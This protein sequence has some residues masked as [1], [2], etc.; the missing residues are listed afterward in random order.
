VRLILASGSPRRRELIAHLGV[1][2]E[3][4]VSGVDEAV[5][6]G[7][8]PDQLVTRLARSKAMEVSG[9]HADAIVLA[10]DTI[11]VLRGDI[12]NKPLDADDA[13]DML[14]RLRGRQHRVITAVAVTRPGGRTRVRRVV[15][16][17]TM[18]PYSDSEVEAWIAGGSPFDKAG[19]YAVQDPL[20]A[21]VARHEGC[22][23][24]IVGLPL[25][26]T[27]CMLGAAGVQASTDDL[28]ERCL[29]C[30]L[31]DSSDTQP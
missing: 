4:A 31:R 9:Q 25:W 5:S 8:R 13:R 14:A 12:L 18:R 6:A 16:R 30:P 17:V 22:Y 10:A 26:T 28:P 27:I 21:P 15:T 3:L 24:N 7:E 20:F 19:A 2:F 29:T 11:V 23:C 1:P